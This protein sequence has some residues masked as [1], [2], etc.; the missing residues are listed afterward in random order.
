MQTKTSN[1]CTV[2]YR[3][4]LKA[5]VGKDAPVEQIA[6]ALG[7]TP[8]NVRDRIRSE[9]WRM[10]SAR[11]RKTSPSQRPGVSGTKRPWLPHEDR[12]IRERMASGSTVDKIAET[13]GRTPAAS[14]IA[15]YWA[16]AVR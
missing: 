12:L 6:T 7:R 5:L 11:K 2:A 4:V 15:S 3:E 13:L 10:P 1:P 9:G 8:T 14:S 16:S